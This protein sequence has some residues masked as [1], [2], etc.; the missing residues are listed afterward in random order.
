MRYIQHFFVF[1]VIVGSIQIQA[2]DSISHEKLV[3][4][5]KVELIDRP[6]LMVGMGLTKQLNDD[7]YIGAFY[8]DEAV[9]YSGGK[10]FFEMDV[11]RRMVFKIASKRRVSAASFVRSLKEGIRINSDSKKIKSEGRKISQLLGF[12]R[13]SYRQ[14]DVIAFDYHSNFG[15]RVR[16]N[17]RIVGQIKGSSSFYSLLVNVWVGNR[18]PSSKFKVGIMGGNT[19]EDAVDLLKRFVAL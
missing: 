10:E 11:P 12:L 15:V 4:I 5:Q 1:L 14:G 13:G 16:L 9:H 19:G 6:A 7:Y 2:E 18:P 8:L 17:N 3:S